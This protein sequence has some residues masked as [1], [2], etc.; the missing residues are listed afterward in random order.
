V[1]IQAAWITLLAILMTLQDAT[2]VPAYSLQMAAQ[3]TK[4]ATSM[5]MPS[6]MMAPAT[7]LVARDRD[8]AQLE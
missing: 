4:R 5:R 8:V 1:S 7:I 6:A 2:M 3:I